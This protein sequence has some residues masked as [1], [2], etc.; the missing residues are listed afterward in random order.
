MIGN[1]AR[2]ERKKKRVEDNRL[3]IL[4]AAEKVFAQRGYTQASVD[5]IAGEAQFSKATIYRYFKSKSEIFIE[6][7][8]NSFEA[9]LTELE[10]IRVKE[11]TAEEKIKELI[12]VVL[13]Y[14]ERKKNIIRIFYA[15]KDA[16]SNILKMDPKKEFTH[17]SLHSRFPSNF[18]VRAR[19]ITETMTCIVESGIES[20]EFKP[21]DAELAGSVLGAMIRGFSFRGP[22]L[23]KE[24]S[25]EETAEM[26]HQFFMNGIKKQSK[27]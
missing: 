13:M 9:L 7:I 20:G 15:E 27:I 17:A 21:V 8:K 14:F 24:F 22:F 10:E 26:L 5:E 1:N 23:F 6:V 3:F 11:L 16:V 2:A 18:L 25:L 12:S 19:E 4:E